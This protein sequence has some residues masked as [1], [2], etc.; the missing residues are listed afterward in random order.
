LTNTYACS[1]FWRCEIVSCVRG[2]PVGIITSK[3][4]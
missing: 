3:E 2:G 1:E 4:L